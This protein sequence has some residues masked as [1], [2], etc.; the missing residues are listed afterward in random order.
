VQGI[1]F[2]Q[3]IPPQQLAAHIAGIRAEGFADY[4][5]R[6]AGERAIYTSIIYLEPFRDRNLR[7][8]G[9]D[10]FSEPVRRAAMEQARDSG[11]PAL[12]GKVE[13]VQE[14]GTEVQAGTLMYVPVYRNG[15]P[16]D[17]VEQ[18]RAAL[19]GWSYSPYRMKDLLE[20]LLAHWDDHKT[21][22]VHLQIYAGLEVK[23]DELLYDS[24]PAVIHKID[25][26]YYQQRT[27]D[28]NG[29]HWLL[30]FHAGEGVVPVSYASAW[31]TLAGGIVLSSLL[32]GL[33]LALVRTQARAREIADTLTEELRKSESFLRST[34][35]GLSAHIAVLDDQGAIILTNQA[36]RDFGARNG[37]EPRAVSEGANYLAV[38]DTASGEHSAE[39]TPFAQGIR[40]V[41]AGQRPSFELEYPCHSPDEKR[42]F[43]AHVTP[44]GDDGPRQ[45][46]VAH[47][48]I[49]QRKRAEEAVTRSAEDGK[50][51]LNTIQTQ[52][53]YL[54][55]DHTYGAVNKAHA[56]FNGLQ[57]EDMA[58][59][60]MYDFFPGDIVEVCRQSNVE[61]FTTCKPVHSEEWMPNAAG[62]RRLI[63]ILKSPRLRADGT[64]KYVVC[65]AEDITERKQ[66][67]I[68]LE[69]MSKALATSRDL[70]Q[71][72]IDT[73]PIRVFWKDR[74]CRYLGCNP[75]FAR[76]AGKNAPSD[77]IGLD[78]YAMG[79]AEQADLYRADDRQVMESGQ[80]RLDFEEPQTT[81]DGKPLWLRTSKVPLRDAVGTVIGV[82]GI[83]DDITE[84]KRAEIALLY[85]KQFSEDSLN[86][87]PGVFYMFDATGRFVR[88]NHQFNKV[89]GYTDAELATMRGTDFFTGEDQ[90]RVGEAMQR[91]F[92]QGQ[93]EVPADIQTKDGRKLPHHFQGQRSTI[94][95]QIYLLGVGLDISEQRRTQQALENERTH[96]HTL[97]S[98]I[99]DLIW[100]KAVDGTYLA[101]N[102]EFERFVGAAESDILGKTDYDFVPS[103]L[104]DSFREHDRAAMAAGEIS[105]N[106][107][108][109]TYASDGRCVLLETTKIPMSTPDGRLVGVL[110]IGHNITEREAHQ[111]QLEQVAHFDTLT[112]LPNRV[113]LADRLQQALVQA[114]RHDRMLAVAYLDLDGFKAINDH[115]GHQAGDHLLT[116]LSG[117]MKH[118]L[119]EGDTLARLGGDEFVA[120]LLDLPDVES[121]A[122]MLSRLLAA[123]AE[124][125]YEDGNALR[126]SASLGVTFYP[127]AEAVDADQLLRQADQAMY[128]AKLTGKNRYHIFDTEQDRSVRGHHESLER[129]RQALDAR[130]FV[131]YY[132]PKVNMRTGVVIGAEALIRWQH[133][134]RGLLPPAAF[135]PLI[136]DH[137]L[138]I[139]IGEWV[140]EKAMTQ[141]ETWKAAG[142]ALPVSVNIDA[143]HLGQADFVERLRQRLLA[144]PA[145]AAGDLELEV[146]ETSALQDIAYVSGVILACRERGVGF[147]LDDFGTG[148]SSL[149]YLKRL[150]AGLLKID[151]S[152]VR[153]MLDD[154]DDLAIL[155]GV[156]GLASAFRSQTIAEGV[157]TLVHGEILLQLGCE[158][159]QGY[160]I[161]RPMPAEDLPGWLAAWRSPS[162]WL[163]QAPISRDDLPILF[164]W[165][166][167]RAWVLKVVEFIRGEGDPLPQMDPEQCRVGQWLKAEARLPKENH[168][169]IEALWSFHIEIH[170]LA[171]EL[172][173]LKLNGQMDAAMTQLSELHRL[174]DHLLAQF[175][176]MLRQ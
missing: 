142:L 7:A 9:F 157:E 169:A 68:A 107:E 122:P 67:E 65:A 2:S 55:D 166:E 162:S 110:G 156:L 60:D 96:L 24:H 167:N 97:V 119:R 72:I 170:E 111:K 129:I 11:V 4:T 29:Q 28:F 5:V 117:H 37:I 20:G 125:V 13:L 165:V 87:L 44:F 8:F 18:R 57:I 43:I 32:S 137:P 79:W 121:T 61:V 91:V 34:V 116:T 12:S 108:W 127:Q 62:D 88:W 130:E 56:E 98:T 86:A 120:I 71:K 168:L 149:T 171:S 135:L 92:V 152:F 3:V 150:P 76:D 132:Q 115:Y 143:I 1:G 31:A 46:I 49:T 159:A 77:L 27:I 47:E 155:S 153:D 38:C 146:L 148:Y 136:T 6:P 17:S 63:S 133:P 124:V 176:G 104:A 94:G 73:A 64:V 52:I 48:N 172:I 42:W 14:T 69:E 51:L 19:I 126:V 100:L 40:E 101:C 22:R 10:M 131:L 123:A 158:L 141:I 174:R 139:E 53:W 93:A 45:V 25:P 26:R 145:L 33:M 82:L 163:N 39:A 78:D 74:D 113:L 173:R 99:P 84:R 36:Y 50:I 114:Q 134:E 30:A 138:A 164:A 58:F 21:R 35:D 70:L 160:A 140:L 75:L 83:Y 85:E 81:P 41:L 95:D 90:R 54:T 89:T 66:A 128:Q 16:T 102:S 151:Q 105:R 118:A 161:A 154:P 23:T 175:V 103:E 80:S 112:G 109:I 147:A 15:A 59:K 106:E 144:H